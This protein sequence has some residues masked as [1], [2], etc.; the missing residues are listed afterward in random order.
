[1]AIGDDLQIL[2]GMV[3]IRD[4]AGIARGTM[5]DAAA[6][7]ADGP[8]AEGQALTR[9]GFDRPPAFALPPGMLTG[10]DGAADIRL[11]DGVNTEYASASGGKLSPVKAPGLGKGPV[12]GT[13]TADSERV[14]ASSPMAAPSPGVVRGSEIMRQAME[15]Q[16]RQ[17]LMQQLFHGLGQIVGGIR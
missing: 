14:V 10:S 17:E 16:K 1:M 9:Q 8:H 12:P 13:P 7:A 4:R 6:A 2:L 11:P 5:A 15:T 3:P